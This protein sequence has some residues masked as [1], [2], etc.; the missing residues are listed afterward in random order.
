MI[1]PLSSQTLS[2][3]FGL[4]LLFFLFDS[5][6]NVG[7]KAVEIFNS[8]PDSQSCFSHEKPL[9]FSSQ[10]LISFLLYFLFGSLWKKKVVEICNPKSNTG[11]SIWILIILNKITS[12]VHQ[13]NEKNVEKKWYGIEE[14]IKEDEGERE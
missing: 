12:N 7:R 3:N 5:L 11:L 4:T 13:Q 6:E 8:K 10:F 9:F 14:K 1:R 2:G